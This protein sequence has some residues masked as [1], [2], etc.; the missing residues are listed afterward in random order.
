M[1]MQAVI[2]AAG[3][4]TRTYPLTMNKPKPLLK[5]LDR[6]VLEHN[7]DQLDGLVD[8]VIIVVGFMKE[9]IMD[10]FGDKYKRMKLTYVVQKEQLGTGH[11]LQCA[12]SFINE[13]FIVLNGDDIVSRIDI[14]A[15]IDNH[16]YAILVK[17]VEDVT[18]FGAVMIEKDRVKG[19]VE[20]PSTNIS[21]Y[22]NVAVYLF[23]IDV[24]RIELQKS[25]RGEFEITDYV[26]ELAK[27]GKMEFEV[28]K[29]AWLPIGYPWNYLEA[30]V[31]MLKQFEES[32]ID[33]S[34]KIEEGVTMKGV[35]VVGKNTLIRSGTYIEGPVFIGDECEVGPHAYL[36]KETILMDKVRTRAEIIDSVLMDGVTAKHA[37]Y[38]GHSVIGENTNVAAGTITAD[39]RH[40]SGHNHTLVNGKK[41]D[42]GRKKLGAFIGDNV[43]LGI[44]TLIYP[45]RK[46][47]PNKTTLPGQVVKEDI[48]D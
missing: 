18:R 19:I 47:W 48:V 32:R 22:A 37:C 24:F 10:K 40:D 36:R 39:Y 28:I 20:K 41:V 6:T 31:E 44:G 11:A 1:K 5:V 17:E 46:I 42:T 9:A 38:I 2:M 15:L 7:L 16:D 43:R 35:V 29:G 26:T 8:E 34:A 45:G 30:N 4:S 14:A 3:K 21:K 12:K 27:K 23:D 25:A 13:R 33:K